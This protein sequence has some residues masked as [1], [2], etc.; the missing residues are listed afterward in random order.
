M[1]NGVNKVIL[2]GHLGKD[3]EVRYTQNGNA[4][5]QF[6]LATAKSYNDKQG[7]RVDKTEWHRIVVWGK[8]AEVA[9]EHLAKG[10]QVY[11]EGEIQTREYEAK[12]GGKRYATEI[13]AHTVQFLGKKGDGQN[14]SQSQT[15]NQYQA[16]AKQQSHPVAAAYAGE[17]HYNEDDVPF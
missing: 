3:P 15:P 6:T 11:L 14:Q 8:L 9:G 12:D 16:P 4:V 7:Q 10:R 5:A 2:V 17:H 13:V 1:A